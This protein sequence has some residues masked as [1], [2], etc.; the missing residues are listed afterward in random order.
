MPLQSGSDDV[1]RRMRRSYRS[2]RYLAILDEVRASLPDAAI[3]TDIIVGF[4]GETDADFE[5]TLRVVREA[6]F[7]SAFTFQYS[8]RPGTP[9]A[10]MPDQLPKAVVQERYERLIAVQEEV[11]WAENRAIEGREVEVLVA[12]GE[13][14]KDTETHRLS[15]R[16]QD[17]RLVHFAV[18]EGAER[19]RPGDVVTV[20]VTYGAPHH[21]VADAAL[22]GGT[23]AVRRTAGGDAWAAAQDAPVPGK[24]A[25]SLGIPGVGRPASQPAAPTCR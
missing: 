22:S 25:V 23:Y 4:P 5:E 8:I 12:T 20:G 1:L 19:P 7:S 15:G 3:T 6:R 13:G 10:T 18:P 2:A 11:S 17:N 16:A 9:A 14:R 24:P 21:L